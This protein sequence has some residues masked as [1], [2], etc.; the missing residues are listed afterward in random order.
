M[1]IKIKTGHLYRDASGSVHGPI[2]RRSDANTF[3][4]IEH[5]M[6]SVT[7]LAEYPFGADSSKW[8]SWTADGRVFTCPNVPSGSD[9][10]EEFITPTQDGPLPYNIDHARKLLEADLVELNKAI[11]SIDLKMAQISQL[12][13]AIHKGVKK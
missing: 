4:A 2:H 11:A 13:N 3:P 6:A 5:T 10:V 12:I 9:L 8:R 7:D 1:G